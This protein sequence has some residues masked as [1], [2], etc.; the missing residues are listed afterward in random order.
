MRQILKETNMV[1]KNENIMIKINI[2]WLN[3]KIQT[4]L[5]NIFNCNIDERELCRMQQGMIELENV[6]EILKYNNNN[7]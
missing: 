1:S 5:K 7:D 4:M 2:S 3:Q 6:K